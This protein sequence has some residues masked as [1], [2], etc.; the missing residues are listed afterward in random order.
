MEQPMLKNKPEMKTSKRP[1]RLSVAAL[2][3]Y[4]THPYSNL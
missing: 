2:Y 3:V 1:Q 4:S